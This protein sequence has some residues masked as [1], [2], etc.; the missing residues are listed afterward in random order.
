MNLGLIIGM[1]LLLVGAGIV[2]VSL[3]LLVGGRS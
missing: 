1:G 2:F 3:L